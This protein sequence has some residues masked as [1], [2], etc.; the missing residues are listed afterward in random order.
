MGLIITLFLKRK[1][2]IKYVRTHTLLSLFIC[3]ILVGCAP[4][5]KHTIK[6]EYLKCILTISNT[7]VFPFRYLYWDIKVEIWLIFSFITSGN[8]IL[9]LLIYEKIK[10]LREGERKAGTDPKLRNS[11]LFWENY[12]YVYPSNGFPWHFP[13]Y[14]WAHIQITCFKPC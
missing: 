8:F 11:V 5:K 3:K 12:M 7:F 4:T 14:I 10:G 13:E 2:Y 9:S 1:F 6:V